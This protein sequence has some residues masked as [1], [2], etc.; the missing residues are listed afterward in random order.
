M[1]Q[2][3]KTLALSDSEDRNLDPSIQVIIQ[4]P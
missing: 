1:A 3:L 2:Q 4:V